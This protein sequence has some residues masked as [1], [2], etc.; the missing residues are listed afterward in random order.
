MGGKPRAQPGKLSLQHCRKLGWRAAKV[1]FWMPW[2]KQ[3]KDLFG[4]GDIIV[5]DDQ[6]G[7]LLVQ[8][9]VTSSAPKRVCKILEEC[10]EAAIDWLSAGNRIEVWGWAKRGAAGK[11]KLWTLKSYRIYLSKGEL[12][13][14]TDN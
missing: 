3:R 6:F 4:F 9:C 1:E 13:W 8:A 7:S 10:T 2:T 12:N 14:E 11:R 5:L